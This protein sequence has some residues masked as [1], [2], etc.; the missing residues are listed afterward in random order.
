MLLFRFLDAPS[1]II[2]FNRKNIEHTRCI[3]TSESLN[4]H[5]D[6]AEYR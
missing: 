6:W 1:T 2:S 5:N 4:T 3:G